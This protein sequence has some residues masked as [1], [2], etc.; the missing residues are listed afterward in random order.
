MLEQEFLDLKD[1]IQNNKKPLIG[2]KDACK[3]TE[4]ALEIEELIKSS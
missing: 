1:N 2:L 3:S 4:I